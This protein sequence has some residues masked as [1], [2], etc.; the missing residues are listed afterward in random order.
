MGRYGLLQCNAGATRFAERRGALSKSRGKRVAVGE[1]YF[2]TSAEILPDVHIFV[3]KLTRRYP[4]FVKDLE[5]GKARRVYNATERPPLSARPIPHFK[6]ASLKH[7]SSMSVQYS[8][9]DFCLPD[10]CQ[11][12]EP[13]LLPRAA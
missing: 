12:F 2:S 5:R 10:F 13:Q 3:V 1:P 6:L 11:T 7:Y 9:P 8:L 4:E